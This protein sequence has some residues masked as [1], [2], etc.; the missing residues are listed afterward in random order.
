VNASA[1]QRFRDA[2]AKPHAGFAAALRE[3]QAGRKTGH[4]IWYIFPQLAGLGQSP[5]AVYYGLAGAQ[6]AADYLRDPVL[7]ERL[8]RLL[9]I[10]MTATAFAARR[11]TQNSVS[12]RSLDGC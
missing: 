3:L 2:Q 4:W 1:L 7:G 12:S 10:A 9:T 8:A 5:T 11:I 6:E